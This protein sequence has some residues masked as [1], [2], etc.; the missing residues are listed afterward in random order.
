MTHNSEVSK[1]IFLRVARFSCLIYYMMTISYRMAFIPQFDVFGGGFL[2]AV[3]I[4][5]L[6]DLFYLMDSTVSMLKNNNEIV[7]TDGSEPSRRLSFGNS[8]STRRDMTVIPIPIGD[9]AK[10][11]KIA[12]EVL[13]VLPYEFIG[14]LAGLDNFYALRAIR[15]LRCLYYNQ[16]WRDLTALIEHYKL[17]TTDGAKRILYL[18]LGMAV[19]CHLFACVFYALALRSM[20]HGNLNNWLYNDHL[21][22]IDS[23]N[24]AVILLHPIS[25]R[26]LRSIYWSMQTI[27][28]ITFGDI[29][30]YSQ[31]ETWFCTCYFLFTAA[32]VYFSIANL[33]SVVTNFD[34]A[35]TANLMKIIKFEKYA[36]Y[37]KLPVEI[38]ARVVSYYEH[39]WERMHGIDEQQ[40]R[41]SI[42]FGI[43][44]YL[45]L[46]L[47]CV[48]YIMY[49]LIKFFVSLFSYIQ[50]KC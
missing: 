38:T 30:A 39:Q 2:S 45:N 43:S 14:Y 11:M 20:H 32:L 50:S 36:A 31:T 6:V 4:D 34:S 8:S 5:Y 41:K 12:F 47:F 3:I 7:P 16:Y 15:L 24:G 35:R 37:R 18:A 49:A 17:A 25:F 48:V 1:I 44:E 21:A 46:S 23:T 10:R 27:T 28:S 33:T 19:A 40:V 29:V 42:Y 13:S 26:Y 22:E 9:T